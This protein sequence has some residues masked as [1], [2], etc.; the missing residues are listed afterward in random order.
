MA[1][2]RLP[3]TRGRAM[4]APRYRA[5]PSESIWASVHMMDQGASIHVRLVEELLDELLRTGKAS[6]SLSST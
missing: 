5:G 4:N 6:R 2:P 3:A 1:E